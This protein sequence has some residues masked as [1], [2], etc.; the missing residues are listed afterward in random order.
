MEKAKKNQAVLTLFVCMCGLSS[1]NASV[2][3][4]SS[5]PSCCCCCCGCG[6]TWVF[7]AV[8]ICICCLTCWR[9]GGGRRDNEHKQVFVWW[10]LMIFFFSFPP[11][12]PFLLS[13]F[14]FAAFFFFCSPLFKKKKKENR[15]EWS[16]P[17]FV[18]VYMYVCVRGDKNWKRGKLKKRKALSQREKKDIVCAITSLRSAAPWCF[19]FPLPPLYCPH[20]PSLEFLFFFFSVRSAMGFCFFFFSWLSHTLLFSLVQCS[21]SVDLHAHIYK[22]IYVD[23]WMHFRQLYAL[24]IRRRKKRE[25]EEKK[26]NKK[27]ER[28]RETCNDEKKKKCNDNGSVVVCCF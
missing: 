7:I 13:W 12:F 25:E 15:C 10:L 11:A 3:V 21:F 23:K 14:F 8:P 28:V 27:T 1:K 17:V 5:P 19:F 2:F 20:T 24:A 18:C 9:R 4:L 22:Y 16:H 26:K 6:S